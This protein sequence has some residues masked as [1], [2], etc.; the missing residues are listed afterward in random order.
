[1]ATPKKKPTK[2]IVRKKKAIRSMRKPSEYVK[3]KDKTISSHKMTWNGPA[4]KKRGNF[5]VHP[6]IAPKKGAKPSHSP[7]AWVTQNKEQAAK[8]GEVITVKRRKRAEKLAAGSWKK[9]RDKKEAMSAY[10]KFKRKNGRRAL[11]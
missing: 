4:S 1:M 2:R 6:T 5:S 11:Y 7:K 8:R 9:G 3:N 10:R